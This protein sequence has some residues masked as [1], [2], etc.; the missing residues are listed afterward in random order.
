MLVDSKFKNIF[1][2]QTQQ[3][4]DAELLKIYI[5]EEIQSSVESSDT[6]KIDAFPRAE[7]TNQSKQISKYI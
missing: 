6:N 1:V 3:S 7:E 4:D 2:E 5:L